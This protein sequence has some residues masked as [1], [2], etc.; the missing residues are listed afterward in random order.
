MIKY[1]RDFDLMHL[2]FFKLLQSYPEELSLKKL[3][4][5]FY[6]EK[7]WNDEMTMND[8]SFSNWHKYLN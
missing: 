2:Q 3:E 8:I 7:W 4:F 1:S 5:L 6:W